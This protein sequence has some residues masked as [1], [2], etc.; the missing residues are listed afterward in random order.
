[1][2]VNRK[3]RLHSVVSRE[4]SHSQLI[5]RIT[6]TTIQEV[7]DKNSIFIQTLIGAWQKLNK[8]NRPMSTRVEP[9]L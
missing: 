3:I 2:N 9:K 8:K 6:K 4:K 7:H 5:E 1:M